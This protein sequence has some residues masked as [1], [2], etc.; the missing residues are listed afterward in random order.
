MA[1]GNLVVDPTL[2]GFVGSGPPPPLRTG[3]VS[4][5]NAG[6]VVGSYSD[7]F[8]SHGYVMDSSG[9]FTVVDDPSGINSSYFGSGTISS[10][11]VFGI[12]DAGDVV[13]AYEDAN[14]GTHGF[15]E[16]N[17]NYTTID[18][19]VDTFFSSTQAVDINSAGQI[20]GFSYSGAF[21]DDNGAFTVLNDPAAS[22]PGT[23]PTGINSAGDIVGYITDNDPSGPHFEHGF[24]ATLATG[25]AVTDVPEPGTVA[26][27]GSMVAMLMATKMR[28]RA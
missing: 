24:I 6:Q 11:T 22:V 21:L 7:D 15:V 5:N 2:T 27:F 4:I 20:V 19:P 28:R 10:T 17:G 12:N 16:S 3:A 1:S 8:G 13:G 26:L 18:N 14:Y 25:G 9:N 23:T